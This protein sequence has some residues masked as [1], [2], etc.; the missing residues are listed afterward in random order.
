[1]APEHP[2][3]IIIGYEKQTLKILNVRNNADG[4][5]V[6]LDEIRQSISD[7]FI[8]T[9]HPIPADPHAWIEEVYKMEGIE[10]FVVR[11]KDG[12]AFKLKTEPYSIQHRAKDGV[13]VPRRLF[14]AC[15]MEATDDLKGLFSN[16][17]IVLSQIQEM[18][19][20]VAKIYNHLAARLDAFYNANKHLDRKEFAILGQ[21]ELAK[22]GIFGLAMNRYIGREADL[23]DFMVKHYKDFG[24]KDDPVQTEE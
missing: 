8:V 20:K 5:Y 1:M 23:K 11:L 21:K 14:E 12:K 9:H 13:T 7:D 3:R 15:V 2:F 17:P 6:S 18:E 22:D 16:D 24:I 4:S 19:E 10:G